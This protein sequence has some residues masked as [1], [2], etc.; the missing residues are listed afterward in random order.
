MII[1]GAILIVLGILIKI[2]VLYTIGII[3]LVVGLVLELLGAFHRPFLGKTA[4][5]LEPPPR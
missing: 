2:S 5:L 4:L 3:L 1:L